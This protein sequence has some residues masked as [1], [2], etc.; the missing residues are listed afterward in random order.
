MGEVLLWAIAAPPGLMLVYYSIEVLL[1]ARRIPA[2]AFEAL[3]GPVVIVIPAHNEELV[4]S[5]TVGSL[6]RRIRPE[7]TVLVVADNCSDRTAALAA[8]AGARVLER[9]DASHLGKGFALAFARDELARDPP[10]AVVVLDADCSLERGKLEELA[11]AAVSLGSPVQAVNL[12]KAPQPASPLILLSNFAFWIKNMIRARGVYRLAGGIPLFGT[13]MSFPWDLFARL[14]LSTSDAV[15]DL[16]LA[17]DL[18]M[19]GTKVHLC[20]Q[21]E[22][23]SDA[24][25]LG[26]SLGQRRRWEHGFLRIA[27]RKAVPLIFRGLATRSRHLAVLGMHLAVP[28]L[29]LL[30]ISAILG[31]VITSGGGSMTGHWLPAGALAAALTLAIAATMTIWSLEGRK[32]IR[33]RDLVHAPLYILWKVPVYAGLFTSRQTRWNK[34][35][36]ING[37]N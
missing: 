24:A 31:L 26:D 11:G 20:E 18:A 30:M 5:E 27:A 25:S 9:T 4:I 6:R 12:L 16:K 36:R 32:V 3:D 37:R 15:E 8:E 10:A 35:R 29:A 19:D 28:P 14:D 21:V 22:V 23:V 2:H 1:G 34:T 13:G 33:F 7:T 17:V